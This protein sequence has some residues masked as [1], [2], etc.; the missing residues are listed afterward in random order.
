MDCKIGLASASRSST[1]AVVQCQALREKVV[2]GGLVV[3]TNN[4]PNQPTLRT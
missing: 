2:K 1:A 3:M 4:R